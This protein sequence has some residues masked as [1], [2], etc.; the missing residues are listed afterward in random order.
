MEKPL[1][2]GAFEQMVLLAILRLKDEAYGVAIRRELLD[3]TG[4][5]AALGALYTTLERLEEKELVRSWMGESTAQRGGRAKR[6]FSVT[7]TGLTALRNAQQ[8]YQALLQGLDVLGGSH[9]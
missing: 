2:L 9:A 4:R 3:C 5:D 6:Y 7:K 8:A 1:N